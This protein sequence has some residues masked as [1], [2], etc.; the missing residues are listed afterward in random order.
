M[1]SS[2]VVDD[3]SRR[4]EALARKMW[5]AYVRAQPPEDLRMHVAWDRLVDDETRRGFRAVAR[6]VLREASPG[7][8]KTARPR[9]A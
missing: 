5:A 9:A 2:V 3:D 4:I 6:M 1:P 8:T 7:R